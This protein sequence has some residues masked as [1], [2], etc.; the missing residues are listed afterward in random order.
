MT[1]TSPSELSETPLRPAAKVSLP[2]VPMK[3]ALS[4]VPPVLTASSISGVLPSPV[5]PGP[6]SPV[7]R[8]TVSVSA[9]PTAPR[10]V[11][12]SVLSVV[13]V[14]HATGVSPKRISPATTV[15]VAAPASGMVAT[16]SFGPARYSQAP[17]GGGGGG[18]GGSVPGSASA[19]S[20]AIGAGSMPA[21]S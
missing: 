10:T 19:F 1:S 16:T 12:A 13:A 21:P 17:G 5:A 9:V 20:T 2:L 14:S 8:S 18:G 4:P 11:I 7:D 3:T 15:R 6:S